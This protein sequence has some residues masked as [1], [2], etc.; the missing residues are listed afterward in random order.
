M[1]E[2]N[3]AGSDTYDMGGNAWQWDEESTG[4]AYRGFRGGSFDNYVHYLLPSDGCDAPPTYEAVFSG[5]RVATS[6]PEPGSMA[7]LLAG[8]IGL[9]GYLWRR[10]AVS[11]QMVIGLAMVSLALTAGTARAD[12]FNMPAGQTS[13]QFVTVGDPGNAADHTH[14]LRLGRLH[15]PDGQVRRDR[16][17]VLPVPQ[18]RG[19]DGHL[20]LVQRCTWAA[21]IT[22]RPI[23]ITQSG[24]PGNYSY[25]VTGHLQR[26]RPIVRSSTSPGAMRPA[27][28]TGCKTA[29]PAGAEGPGTTETGAYTLNGAVTNCDLD[30]G[31]PQ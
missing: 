19:E 27:S 29:S 14:R 2:L 24:S 5:F 20:R 21:A 10:P 8:A 26:R 23:G 18:R 7:M 13:L 28:A 11:R 31:N 4:G 16:W 12:V 9:F 15:L 17:P 1:F 25:S 3:G 30:G 6:L 22:I